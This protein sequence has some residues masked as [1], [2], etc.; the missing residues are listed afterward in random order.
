MIYP[1]SIAAMR[2]EGTCH[3]A[4]LL[5]ASSE[6]E[7]IGAG[8]R[9]ARAHY[10]SSEGWRNQDACVGGLATLDPDSINPVVM[11]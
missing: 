6:D 9:A 1:V 10:P 3:A 11:R 7:A 8:L 5:E 2:L 4:L